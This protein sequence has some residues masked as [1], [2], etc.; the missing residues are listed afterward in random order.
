VCLCRFR[1]AKNCGALE[2]KHVGLGSLTYTNIVSAAQRG[3]AA[4]G[5]HPFLGHIPGIRPEA[6][7]RL[8]YSTAI[9][10]CHGIAG[11]LLP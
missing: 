3:I 1:A 5:R 2:K 6:A 7:Q 4:K 11:C 8:S 9:E 10:G